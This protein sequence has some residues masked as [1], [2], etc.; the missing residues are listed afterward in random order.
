MFLLRNVPKKINDVVFWLRNVTF[1]PA[2]LITFSAGRAKT[3]TKGGIFMV[4]RR[5]SSAEAR[6]FHFRFRSYLFTRD[7][8]E[9]ARWR[10]EGWFLKDSDRAFR[11]SHCA[12][13]FGPH[14]KCCRSKLDVAVF[15]LQTFT[16]YIKANI[17]HL[18]AAYLE[19]HHD[20]GTSLCSK[21]NGRGDIAG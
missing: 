14:W 16:Y 5:K 11:A 9:E 18:W 12:Y 2:S 17:Q 20:Q 4:N 6:D 19:R 13:V 7:M 1:S 15:F 10:K 3:L 8:A 21:K